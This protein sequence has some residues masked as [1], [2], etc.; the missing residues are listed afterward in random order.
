LA[1]FPRGVATQGQPHP[2]A[3]H[4]PDH[5]LLTLRFR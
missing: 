3:D 5:E 2:T 4:D 1:V